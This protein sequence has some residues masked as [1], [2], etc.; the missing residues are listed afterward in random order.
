MTCMIFATR[1][2]YLILNRSFFPY[3]IDTIFV[4]GNYSLVLTHFTPITV[5]IIHVS[6]AALDI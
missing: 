4:L 6:H 1:T 5:R 3:L 2:Y